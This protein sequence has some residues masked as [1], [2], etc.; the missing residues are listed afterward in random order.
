MA[1][2]FLVQL[3]DGHYGFPPG[4]DGTLPLM[5]SLRARKDQLQLKR[6]FRAVEASNVIEPRPSG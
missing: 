3:D 5:Y 6:G 1:R 2:R 4:Q